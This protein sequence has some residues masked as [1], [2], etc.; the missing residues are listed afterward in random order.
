MPG[1][2]KEK[3]WRGDDAGG[4]FFQSFGRF[5]LTPQLALLASYA[6]DL[7]WT[8]SDP[9]EFTPGGSVSV[10]AATPYKPK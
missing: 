6:F 3:S 9:K 8:E 10:V 7:I 5:L 1:V 2:S 4:R